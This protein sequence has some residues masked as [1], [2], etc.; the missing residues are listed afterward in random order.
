M[1]KKI[2]VGVALVAVLAVVASALLLQ[3]LRIAREQE[4]SKEAALKAEAE[5]RSDQE[6]RVV[7]L[8]RDQARLGQQNEELANL[9]QSLRSSEA[10][11]GSNAAAL[12]KK[13]SAQ[14]TNSPGNA[15]AAMMEKMMK[16]PAMREMVRSQQ[17]TVM[18][19]M[20]GP[21]FKD[22]ALTPE[23]RQKFTDLLLDNMMKGVEHG[24]AMFKGEGTER[25]EALKAMA[26][27]Q[28]DTSDGIKALLGD[29]RFAQYEGYQKTVGERLQL[30][31]FKQQLEGGG[32]AL[33]EAQ[34]SQLLQIIS[35]EKARTPPVIS[36]DPN[37]SAES[38]KLLASEETMNKQFQWQEELNQRVL[39]RAGEVLTAGQLKEY[40]DFQGQQLN[41]Q[42][43]A[44]KMAREMFGGDSAKP[45][46]KIEV[47]T[48]P[49]AA[50]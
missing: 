32:S 50:K 22:L 42:R 30:N 36:D 37:R 2:L 19:Q 48:G 40:T 31:Q 41:M 15:M 28:K 23:E 13:L 43:M 3:R 45:A 49:A 9:A 1:Q 24:G 11:Q 12:A 39:G 18:Q 38:L 21:L 17:K 25:T 16:D 47:P 14:A 5:A 33:Q 7:E 6:R 46:D 8:R 34:Y 29:E 44:M 20:Y 4:Q 35:E 26:D 10:K 27:Q